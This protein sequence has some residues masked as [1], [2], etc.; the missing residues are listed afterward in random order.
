MSFLANEKNWIS[1]PF[2]PRLVDFVLEQQSGNC[3]G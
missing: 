1:L 3:S 2:R